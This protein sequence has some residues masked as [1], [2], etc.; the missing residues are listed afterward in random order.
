[1]ETI[2]ESLFN[3]KNGGGTIDVDE[4]INPNPFGEG[5]DGTTAIE[6]LNDSQTKNIRD[7]K[8]ILYNNRIKREEMLRMTG[9]I[10][11]TTRD[12]DM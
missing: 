7:A 10:L 2:Q 4:K 6:L 5:I 8:T 3:N 12:S 9:N 11:Q 1:M